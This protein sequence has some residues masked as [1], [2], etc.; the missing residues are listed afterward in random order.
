M[1]LKTRAKKEDWPGL[2]TQ[3]EHK[4]STEAT[5][6]TAE[7]AAENATLTA[8]FQKRV[9]QRLLRIEQRYPYDAT[10]VRT[11]EGK[12]TVVFRIRDLTAAFKDM[13]DGLPTG[14][15]NK[16]SPIY[17]LLRKLDGECDV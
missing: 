12:N 15:L 14:D 2:R 17:E 11:R 4:A 5:Q 1:A 3:A 10:E 16:N 13:A 8:E 9:L 6:R 7:A